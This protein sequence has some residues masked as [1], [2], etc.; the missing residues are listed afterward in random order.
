[1]SDPQ[2]QDVEMTTD[3]IMAL[4]RPYLVGDKETVEERSERIK[5]ATKDSV[6]LTPGQLKTLRNRT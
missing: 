2:D 1:M 6:R 3:E 4:T 5:K